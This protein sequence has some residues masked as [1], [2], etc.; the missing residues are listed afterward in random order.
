MGLERAEVDLRLVGNL[1]LL[2]VVVLNI[3]GWGRVAQ[4]GVDQ[5]GAKCCGLSYCSH[6]RVGLLLWVERSDP[7]HLPSILRHVRLCQR[8]GCRH[9]VVVIWTPCGSYEQMTPHD[10]RMV[11][12][13]RMCHGTPSH[14]AS[15]TA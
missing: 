1:G 8:Y 11:Y 4:R 13:V 15:H 14:T 12:A 6:S 9:S 10:Q 7:L 2:V 3:V 5:L